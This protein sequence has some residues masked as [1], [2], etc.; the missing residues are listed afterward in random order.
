VGAVLADWPGVVDALAGR[1]QDDVEL[2]LR[3][4]HGLRHFDVAISPVRDRRG[5][6]VGRLFVVHD[7][8]ER[9]RRERELER[10][11]D[12]LEG[13]AS[14]HSHE[15]RNPLNVANGYVET[16]RDTGDISSFDEGERSHDRRRVFETGYTSSTD[17]SGFWLAIARTVVDAHGWDVAVT[18][19]ADGGARVEVT[20][21]VAARRRVGECGSH[22]RSLA[23]DG[24]AESGAGVGPAT[25]IGMTDGG[26]RPLGPTA[27]VGRL[28]TD[29]VVSIILYLVVGVTHER[30]RALTRRSDGQSAYPP[31]LTYT[32]AWR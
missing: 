11:N 14:F 32:T 10:Q 17:G 12:Q 23:C 25:A 27:S 8:T 18:E 15:L 30:S 5:E 19:S 20:G 13:F 31:A 1:Y 29:I 24:G 21:K 26:V 3:T 9:R 7:V 4:R 22:G 28:D 6:V 16:V 2:S